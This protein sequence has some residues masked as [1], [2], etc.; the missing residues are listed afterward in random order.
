MQNLNIMKTC[1]AFIRNLRLSAVMLLCV[2]SA[3]LTPPHAALAQ[4]DPQDG[5]AQVDPQDVIAQPPTV[6][7]VAI[8]SAAP[9]TGYY[10][11]GDTIQATVTFDEAVN[12]TGGPAVN[13]EHRWCEAR[14][15]Y[16]WGVA[17]R[18]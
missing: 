5:L 4:G 16:K 17:A 11:A 3:L 13:V 12:V 10:K 14:R 1:N 9:T 6:S 2:A 18:L 8:I 15:L 7:S